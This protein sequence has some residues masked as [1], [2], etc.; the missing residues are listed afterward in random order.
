M[1]VAIHSDEPMQD[2]EKID[3]DEDGDVFVATKP[4]Y[5]K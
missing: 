5:D 3:Y 1:L 2:Y 4:C